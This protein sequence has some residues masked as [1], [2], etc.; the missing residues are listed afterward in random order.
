LASRARRRVH[1]EAGDNRSEVGGGQLQR[2]AQ[3][4]ID[5]C[6]KGDVQALVEVLD[7]EVVGWSDLGGLSTRFPKIVGGVS[8]VVEGV[9][10]FFGPASALRLVPA[11]VNGEPGVVGLRRDQP[12]AVTALKLRK[13]RI[14]GIYSIVDRAKLKHVHLAAHA[15]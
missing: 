12:F 13:G 3:A 4:F 8:D 14:A 1:A 6:S 2:V 10:R 5:A 9:L 11:E 15:Y 7:P